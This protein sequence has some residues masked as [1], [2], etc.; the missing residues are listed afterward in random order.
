MRISSNLVDGFVDVFVASIEMRAMRVYVAK[1]GRPVK[2]RPAWIRLTARQ[3]GDRPGVDRD[4]RP[5]MKPKRSL[6]AARR[7]I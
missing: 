5:A 4:Y 2:D 3:W 6:V 7:M 1:I